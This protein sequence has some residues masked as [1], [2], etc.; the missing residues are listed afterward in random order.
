M[1]FAAL[2]DQLVLTPAGLTATGF[3]RSDT[4]EGDLALGYLN[5]GRTNVLHLPVVGA[6]DGG[7]ATTIADL[8]R[9]WRA[10]RTGEI[11]TPAT[12]AEMTRFIGV[13]LRT[14]FTGEPRHVRRIGMLSDYESTGMLPPLPDSAVRPSDA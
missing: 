13:F 5:D 12:L 2:L 6:G 11:V 1:P 7:L 9:F 4:P 10:L 3:P 14:D 8:E